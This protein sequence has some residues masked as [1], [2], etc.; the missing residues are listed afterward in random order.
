M[1][2]LEALSNISDCLNEEPFEEHF[3]NIMMAVLPLINHENVRVGYSLLKTLALL[4]LEY[5]PVIQTSFHSEI[6]GFMIRSIGS[7]SGNKIKGRAVSGVLN[8][9]SGKPF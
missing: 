4:C 1:G 7:G 9:C 3:E 5:T 2:G 6:L 8:F